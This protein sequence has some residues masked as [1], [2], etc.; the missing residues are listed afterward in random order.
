MYVP[1]KYACRSRVIGT[2]ET[3][4]DEGEGEGKNN[5]HSSPHMVASL[6]FTITSS[7]ILYGLYTTGLPKP[8]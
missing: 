7:D 6:S 4:E 1:H 5:V 2:T 8:K 3:D